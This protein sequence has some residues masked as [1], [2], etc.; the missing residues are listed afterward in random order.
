MYF[1]SIENFTLLYFY[2]IGYCDKRITAITL[3]S[4][5]ASVLPGCL[6]KDSAIVYQHEFV[7]STTK[8]DD[9]SQLLEKSISEIPRSKLTDQA[10]ELKDDVT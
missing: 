9:L 2:I 3:I 10:L 8:K 4:K 6:P 1:I 5:Q 7:S